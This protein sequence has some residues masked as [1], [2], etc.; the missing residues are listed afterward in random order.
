[1]NSTIAHK[2]HRLL[3]EENIDAWLGQTINPDGPS[4]K[5]SVEI[6]ATAARPLTRVSFDKILGVAATH[7]LEL[8][9]GRAPRKAVVLS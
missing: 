7:G 1:M 3:H 4:G 8:E 6:R 9:L 5:W 2:V